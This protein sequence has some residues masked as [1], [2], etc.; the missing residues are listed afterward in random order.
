[1]R[2]NPLWYAMTEVLEDTTLGNILAMNTYQI[3]LSFV[4]PLQQVC[5]GML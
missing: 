3:V 4:L 5:V 1:M 2:L